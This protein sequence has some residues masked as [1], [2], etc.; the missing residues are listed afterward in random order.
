MWRQLTKVEAVWVHRFEAQD[1]AVKTAVRA[2]VPV[3]VVLTREAAIVKARVAM[4]RAALTEASVMIALTVGAA[5]AREAEVMAKVTGAIRM[6]VKAVAAVRL[7][8]DGQI[9]GQLMREVWRWR[10]RS[11]ERRVG[12]EC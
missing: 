5:L 11:E 7:N 9:L 2:L 10:C 3:M 1:A 8:S 4:V 6:V 12:K